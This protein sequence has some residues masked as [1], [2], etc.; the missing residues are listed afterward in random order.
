MSIGI[1]T[2]RCDPA[3]TYRVTLRKPLELRY[4][5]L[6]PR[7][8][9]AGI[10]CPTSNLVWG[11]KTKILLIWM[12]KFCYCIS[13][14]KKKWSLLPWRAYIPYSVKFVK[15][16][17]NRMPL[18][19]KIW[20][21]IPYFYRSIWF[22]LSIYTD[23]RAHQIDPKNL[24]YIQKWTLVFKKHYLRWRYVQSQLRNE[25][26]FFILVTLSTKKLFVYS[27]P[28]D[29]LL[30]AMFSDIIVYLF[31]E[32]FLLSFDECIAKFKYHIEWNSIRNSKNEPGYQN[33][34]IEYCDDHFHSISYWVVNETNP[35]QPI[36]TIISHDTPCI[37]IFYSI[38]N[39]FAHLEIS[40]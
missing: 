14:K 19:H 36:Q 24:H 31:R 38:E 2:S 3:T 28:E 11:V 8:P 40:I 18:C 25:I 4:L 13:K 9:G 39:R 26:N 35:S 7:T 27:S 30:Y 22:S 16:R 34:R 12:K 33:N 29:Y 20:R 6:F 37:F 1:F 17:K 21:C 15:I 10:I 5:Q 23:N 32:S